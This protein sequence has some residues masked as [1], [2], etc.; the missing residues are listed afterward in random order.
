MKSARNAFAVALSSVACLMLLVA[1]CVTQPLQNSA[2][3]VAASGDQSAGAST[4]VGQPEPL[5][6]SRYPVKELENAV[7]I[8]FDRLLVQTVELAGFQ[9]IWAPQA[10]DLILYDLKDGSVRWTLTRK[11][12]PG[13]IDRIIP[14]LEA[15]YITGKGEKGANNRL[16]AVASESGAILWQRDP[17]D[18]V[19]RITPLPQGNVALFSSPKQGDLEVTAVDLQDGKDLWS[20]SLKDCVDPAS[21]EHSIQ[22]FQGDGLIAGRSLLRLSLNSGKIRWSIPFT[23]TKGESFS[24]EFERPHLVLSDGANVKSLDPE[25]GRTIWKLEPSG[26]S[27]P[28]LHLRRGKLFLAFIKE[29]TQILQGLDPVTGNTLWEKELPEVLRGPLLYHTNGALFFSTRNS[30][31]A[32]DGDSGRQ[33]FSADLPESLRSPLGLPDQ[34]VVAGDTVIVCREVGIAAFSLESGIPVFQHAVGGSLSFTN[35]YLSHKL[36]ARYGARS[37]PESRS[38]TAVKAATDFSIQSAARSMA[39]SQMSLDYTLMQTQ[40]VLSSS[41]SSSSERQAALTQREMAIQANYAQQMIAAQTQL[42]AATVNLVAAAAG[43]GMAI[44][45][46]WVRG[47]VD[48]NDLQTRMSNLTHQRTLQS[49]YFLRP[50]YAD[51]WGVTLVRLSDGKRADL[52]LAADNG[53]LCINGANVP[54]LLI[55]ADGKRL[56]AKGLEPHPTEYYT[57]PAWG[58]VYQFFPATFQIPHSALMA[59]DLDTIPFVVHG[60]AG[61]TDLQWPALSAQ[62]QELL[63]A[64]YLGDAQRVGALVKQG[65]NVN[66][67]DTYGYNALFYASIVDSK[68]VV[69][70]LLKAGCDAR[71]RDANRWLPYHY[72]LLTV[73]NCKSA[74]ILAKAG[75]G[76]PETILPPQET[77]TTA[78]TSSEAKS[79][80]S[81]N[82][83]SIPA[84]KQGPSAIPA[85]KIAV[86]GRT[87]DWMGIP[88]LLV[89]VPSDSK[90]DTPGTDLKEIYLSTDGYNLFVR[91]CLAGP[92]QLST[93]IANRFSRF[94]LHF[95]HEVGDQRTLEYQIYYYRKGNRWNAQI[96]LDNKKNGLWSSVAEGE[97]RKTPDGFE[98]KFPLNSARKFLSAGTTYQGYASVGYKPVNLPW[99][100]ADTAG[101]IEIRY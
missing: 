35:A 40:S 85:G 79:E 94:Y 6:I 100:E 17:T 93:S 62:E 89:D 49:G 96:G 87:G 92:A 11:L 88:P 56:I 29:G 24:M 50:Y 68:K 98:A 60:S 19:T 59:F 45:E 4:A 73:A 25:T 18:R 33:R 63:D 26:L 83:A 23:K 38:L 47:N 51:G 55:S 30:L 65:V 15:I 9:H 64:A 95:A 80:A 99:I 67:K 22:V 27:A 42:M 76:A 36:A 72:N 10:G 2:Q 43:I 37:K 48:I 5:W 101:P 90:G 66:V 7:M 84:N 14:G 71:A 20:A 57:K 69:N 34:V 91:F 78:G 3:D 39:Q 54:L 52:P 44:R 16:I 21:G 58:P 82:A 70:L 53:A 32:L 61:R 46:G 31:Y 97:A 41:S 28:L 1:G 74:T 77:R 13:S 81:G 12:L 86:D 75:S 8:G